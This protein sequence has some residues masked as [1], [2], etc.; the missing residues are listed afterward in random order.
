MIWCLDTLFFFDV[1]FSCPFCKSSLYEF[2]LYSS[3]YM[4][5]FGQDSVHDWRTLKALQSIGWVWLSISKVS[6]LTVELV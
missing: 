2:N 1:S 5:T 6:R 4:S 3:V